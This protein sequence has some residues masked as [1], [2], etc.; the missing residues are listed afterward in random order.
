MRLG[1][2]KGHMNDVKLTADMLEAFAASGFVPPTMTFTKPDPRGLEY[3]V[4]QAK[5]R[6]HKTVEVY[7]TGNQYFMVFEDLLYFCRW[8]MSVT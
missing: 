4:F 5:M 6:D 7:H 3:G 1:I 2:V 8:A